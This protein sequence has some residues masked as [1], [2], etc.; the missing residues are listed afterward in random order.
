MYLDGLLE[1]LSQSAVGCYWGHQFAGALSYA[2]DIVLLASC[3][4]SLR[5]MLSICDSYATSHGLVFNAAETQLICF[6]QRLTSSPLS[7][8]N[9]TVRGLSNTSRTYPALRSRRQA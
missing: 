1:R 5:R 8:D 7:P 9:V 4:T 6:R 3:A 2:D